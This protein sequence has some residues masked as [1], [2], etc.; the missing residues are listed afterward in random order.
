MHS[1][2]EYREIDVQEYM[3][4]GATQ[5]EGAAEDALARISATGDAD[6]LDPGRP[7][8]PC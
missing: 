1:T 4:G 8:R 2:H 6:F 5:G 3:R 7:L